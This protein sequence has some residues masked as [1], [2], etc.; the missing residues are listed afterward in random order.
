MRVY[1]PAVSSQL[2]APEPPLEK[3]WV[4]DP[5]AGTDAEGIELL[6]DDA[7]TEAA[8]GSLMLLRDHPE[9]ALVRL[10][11]AVDTSTATPIGESTSGICCVQPGPLTWRDV[12]AFFVDEDEAASNVEACIG[13]QT[14]VEADEAIALLWERSLLWHDA[15]ERLALIARFSRSDET[16]LSLG[17]ER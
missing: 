5:P 6:E 7:Q 2:R 12:V 17:D 10:V 4:A 13:A 11:L 16:P 3:G 15:V 8:L 14:Q 1:I 9:N